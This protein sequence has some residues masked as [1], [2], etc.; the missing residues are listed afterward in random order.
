MSYM[1]AAELLELAADIAGSHGGLTMNQIDER[2]EGVEAK[3]ARRNT[4][5]A[6]DAIRRVFGDKLIEDKDYAGHKRLR[7]EH[8]ALRDLVDVTASELASFDQAI[9]ALER[10]NDVEGAASLTSLRTKVRLATPPASQRRLEPDYEA[11][12]AARSLI[13]RPG[14]RPRVDEATMARVTEAILSLKRLVFSYESK[15]KRVT[16]LVDPFGVIT[17]H[18]VYLVAR[19]V[20]S[21]Q[22]PSVWRVDRMAD[23]VVSEDAAVVPDDFRVQ[24]FARR[25]FGAYHSQDEYGENVWR[26]SAKAASNARDFRFHPDQ[27][28]EEHADG[29]LTVR[30]Q[31]SGHLEMVWFLYA[32]GN[33]VEVIAPQTV[34]DLVAGHQ[35]D[36]FE[37]AP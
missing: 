37:G 32:W 13:A 19:V 3:S 1:K 35:R 34:R 12:L 33:Q 7:F 36:D 11:L 14:P 8:G 5:R 25:S 4:Q 28:I 15:G 29:S 6:L 10:Q 31:A 23:V 21:H 2:W 22:N 24:D 16:R 9:A 20:G 30:F 27:M 17:G 26:F 18:R